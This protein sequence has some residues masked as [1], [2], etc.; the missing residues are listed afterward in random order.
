MKS[1]PQTT[2]TLIHYGYG[3]HFTQFFN[4]LKM[5]LFIIVI[6]STSY[7]GSIL[8]AVG[9]SKIRY[10]QG[11]DNYNTHVNRQTKP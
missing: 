9:K 11:R 2:F 3:Y 4:K 8:T 10:I 6:I 5:L 7:N 1:N